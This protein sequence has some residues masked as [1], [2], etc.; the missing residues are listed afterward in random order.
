MFSD[1]NE[2][3]IKSRKIIWE[4]SKYLEIRNYF[5]L[6]EICQNFWYV[7]NAIYLLAERNLYH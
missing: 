5:G 6:N 3:K 1:H 4:I 2:I 7:A